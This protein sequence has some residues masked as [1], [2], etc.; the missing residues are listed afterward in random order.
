M[1]LALT[2]APHTMDAFTLTLPIR[3]VSEANQ[4]EHWAKKAKRA[5]GH[6]S[7]VAWALSSRG[8]KGLLGRP[9][10][11][12]LT[13]IAPRGLDADNL[14]GSF[15]HVQDGVADALGIDD[16]HIVWVYEQRKGKP[17]EYAVEIR[18]EPNVCPF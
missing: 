3:T 18:I 14:A 12:T 4:R 16:R 11:V 6:R 8:V 15:K 10:S 9:L 2:H 5:K 7:V 1:S 13:R 17:K